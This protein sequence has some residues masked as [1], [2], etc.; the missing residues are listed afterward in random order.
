MVSEPYAPF[1]GTITAKEKVAVKRRNPVKR[2]LEKTVTLRTTTK[3]KVAIT[4]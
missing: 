1:V 2:E 4:T 3:E